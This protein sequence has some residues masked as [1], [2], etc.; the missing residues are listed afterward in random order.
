MSSIPQCRIEQIG[1]ATSPLFIIQQEIDGIQHT[2]D[3]KFESHQQALDYILQ[4]GWQV[5][6]ERPTDS[7]IIASRF[8]KP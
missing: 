2:L 6:R 1:S 4:Q 5:Q 8:L 7:M 3:K